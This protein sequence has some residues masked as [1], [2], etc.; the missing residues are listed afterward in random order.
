MKRL[1]G[2]C[3]TTLSQ[4]KLL[5]ELRYILGDP[6]AVSRVDKMVVVNVYRPFCRP[7]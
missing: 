2:Y 1:Q 7:D 3:N 4:L 6:G 5:S